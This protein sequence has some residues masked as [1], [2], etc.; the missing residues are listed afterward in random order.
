[1][2]SPLAGSELASSSYLQNIAGHRVED[3]EE[4]FEMEFLEEGVFDDGGGDVVAFWDLELGLEAGARG[5]VVFL[6]GGAEAEVELV[7]GAD[8]DAEG[9]EVDGA[10]DLRLDVILVESKHAELIV[11][12]RGATGFVG[13]VC[14]LLLWGLL[15][16][17]WRHSLFILFC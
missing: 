7:G 10:V 1:M 12:G 5:G 15:L 6:P 2:I 13:V 3:V 11:G 14:T 16:R 9:V 4:G 8:G 17:W